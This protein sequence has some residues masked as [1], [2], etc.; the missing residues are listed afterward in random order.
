MDVFL[1][2]NDSDFTNHYNT[3]KD[4]AFVCKGIYAVG[5]DAEFLDKNNFP[6]SFEQ[7]EQWVKNNSQGIVPCIVQIAA[8]DFCMIINLVK[9]KNNLP[10]KLLKIFTSKAWIKAGVNIDNDMLVLSNAYNLGHCSGTFELQS[11][12]MIQGCQTPNLAFL[13]GQAKKKSLSDWSQPLTDNQIKYAM[14]DA[15]MSY[16]VFKHYI[17]LLQ[18]KIIKTRTTSYT[19]YIG[20]VNEYCQKNSLT[21][22]CNFNQIDNDNFE[23]IAI[24]DDKTYKATARGKKKAKEEVFKQIYETIS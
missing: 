21:I 2:E 20:K 5:F 14:N 4:K 24:C 11:L 23:C 6:E 18:V 17:D 19:N 3:L 10:L 12:A 7:S 13:T 1:I 22:E 16:N 8:K 9:M 15:F